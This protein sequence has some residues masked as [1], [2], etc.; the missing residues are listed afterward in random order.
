MIYTYEIEPEFTRWDYV[1][2]FFTDL[3]NL[4][5]FPPIIIMFL[6]VLYLY[7]TFSKESTSSEI[8]PGAVISVTSGLGVSPLLEISSCGK[9]VTTLHDGELVFAG[10]TEAE[11]KRFIL[12]IVS[13]GNRIIVI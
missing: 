11:V 8:K 2:G 7:E 10:K 3:E 6:M 9:K 1:L 12:R 4:V 13:D 5:I